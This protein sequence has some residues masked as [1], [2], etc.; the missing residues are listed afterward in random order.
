MSSQIQIQFALDHPSALSVL[1]SVA[2]YVDIVE[3]GTPLVKRFG[4]SIIPTLATLAPG[5]LLL[6]DTKTADGGAKEATMFYDA[7][8]HLVTVLASAS[9]ATIVSAAEV[10][11]ERGR[12]L[13]LD[14]VGLV[15]PITALGALT[16][17]SGLTHIAIHSS[18]DDRAAGLGDTARG[19]TAAAE[20][21]RF[22]RQVVVAGGITEDTFGEAA[23]S[24]A[25][26]VVVG[27]EIWGSKDPVGTVQRM[28]EALG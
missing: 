11:A 25:S 8:A 4:L 24:G 2:P 23:S 14:T 18:L 7:G 16:L 12:G 1:E 21:T 17:P 3:A 15:D 6:A 9:P 10:A 26:V 19:F 28:R 20:A 27:R 22:G 5:H 13:V